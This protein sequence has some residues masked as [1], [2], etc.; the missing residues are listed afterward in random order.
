MLRV[1]LKRRSSRGRDGDGRDLGCDTI[2]VPMRIPPNP[3]IVQHFRVMPL[4]KHPRRVVVVRGTRKSRKLTAAMCLTSTLQSLRTM[5]WQRA[6]P[7]QTN[8]VNA[9]STSA[10]RCVWTWRTLCLTLQWDRHPTTETQLS[11]SN[12]KVKVVATEAANR[13]NPC[14]KTRSAELSV[15]RRAY[16]DH[17]CTYRTNYPPMAAQCWVAGCRGRW[18]HQRDEPL[19]QA[20]LQQ[21]EREK[22]QSRV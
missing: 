2:W 6:S 16:R 3:R 17:L 15:R 21:G 13:V 18:L 4:W 20:P 12:K 8:T 19:A 1:C 10:C 11:K 22:W 7:F 14:D 9:H 5:L